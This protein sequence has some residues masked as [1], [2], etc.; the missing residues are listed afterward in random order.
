MT[1]NTSGHEEHAPFEQT[2]AQELH[3][4]QEHLKNS[5]KLSAEAHRGWQQTPAVF[6]ADDEH[7]SGSQGRQAPAD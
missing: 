2:H 6:E 5:K 3:S 1:E 7:H 4:A